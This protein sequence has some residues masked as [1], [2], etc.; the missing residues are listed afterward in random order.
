MLT[1]ARIVMLASARI[2]MP[3]PIRIVMPTITRIA[4]ITAILIART[5]GDIYLT[6]KSGL[7]RT[8]RS[9]SSIG[10]AKNSICILL[11]KLQI[12]SNIDYSF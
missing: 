4:I 3:T 11:I 1:S 6:L 5:I 9:K 12:A 8:L 7:M 10:L 2:V